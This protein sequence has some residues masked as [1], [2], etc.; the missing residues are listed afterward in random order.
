MSTRRDEAMAA[1]RDWSI[2]GRRADLVAAAWQAGET[3]VSALA[4]ASRTSRPTVYADLRSRGIDPDHRPKEDTD[5]SAPV[6]IDGIDGTSLENVQ[7]LVDQFA[8]KHPGDDDAITGYIRSTTPIFYAVHRYNELRSL[9]AAEEHARRER[10][11]ALHLVETRWEA[12]NTAANWLAAHHAYVV[13]VADAH[14][15]IDMWADRA[16]AAAKATG[17]EGDPTA[18]LIRVYRERILVEGHPPV[19]PGTYGDNEARQLRENL[20]RTH[21]RR[22]KLAA[23]TLGMARPATQ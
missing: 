7:E 17:F 15:A 3:N 16:A 19:E 14:I 11:R 23:E 4:E 13:A 18:D 5:M 9:L 21:E 8:R 6:V 10:D 22:K 20:D 1:L 12:L 2:P